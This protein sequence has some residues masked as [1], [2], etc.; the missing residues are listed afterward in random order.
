MGQQVSM[1]ISVCVCLPACLYLYV[2]TGG[3]VKQEVGGIGGGGAGRAVARD[4][5][6]SLPRNHIFFFFCCAIR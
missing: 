2:G 3:S 1:I 4:L 5:R 6:L